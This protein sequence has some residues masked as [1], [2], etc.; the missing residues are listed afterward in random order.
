MCG[1]ETV[2][3]WSAFRLRLSRTTMGDAAGHASAS[4]HVVTCDTISNERCSVGQVVAGGV[5]LAARR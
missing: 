1:L 2:A 5:T 4:Q 3:W